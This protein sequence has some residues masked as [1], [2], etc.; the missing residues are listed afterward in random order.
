MNYMFYQKN[1]QKND[2]KYK[3]FRGLVIHT[4]KNENEKEGRDTLK[5]IIT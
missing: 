5:E 4:G 3:L 2:K 1:K